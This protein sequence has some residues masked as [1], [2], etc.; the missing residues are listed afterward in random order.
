MERYV[1]SFDIVVIGGGPAGSMAALTAADKGLSV[2]MVERD[3]VVGSP[4]RCAEG[5]DD[6]GLCEFFEPDPVWI[7]TK[8]TGYSL[9]APDSTVVE[10]NANGYE[11]YIL[12]RLIF[13]RMIAE[14][15]AA[16]GAAIMTGTEAVGMSDFTG[17]QR[18]VTLASDGRNWDVGAKVVVAADGLESR[19]ARWAGLKTHSSAHNMETAAM[20]ILAGV[21][22]DES[23]FQ[24]YFT[25]EFAPGGYAWVF[26]KSNRTANVGLGISGDYAKDKSPLA[27]LD[28]FCE[29]YFPNVAVV[30]RTVGGVPCTGGIKK[31]IADGLLVAG[32][33]AHMANP[34]TG[35]GI[36]NSM[37]A[38]K[39]AGEVAEKA[40]AKGQANESALGDYV[41]HCDDRFAKM[42]RRFYKL[43]EGIFTIPEDQLN[44]LARE[45]N[46]IPKEKRT[47]VRVLRSALIKRPELLLVLARVVF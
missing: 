11:G 32:D 39:L 34:I 14:K 20:Y 9:V 33:S 35:G 5:V 31:I 46:S 44:A 7:S 15:A 3:S 36:I 43:K 13:D 21:D 45:M 40:L 16:S 38:G 42:N 23:V 37:I 22:V 24:L 10:M 4:V 17:G 27:C 30:G 18:T 2:L 41:H 1:E 19:V 12:E 26:P 25:P 28:D 6:K 47:P 29:K 8:I